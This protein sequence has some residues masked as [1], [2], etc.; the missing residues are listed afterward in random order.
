MRQYAFYFTRIDH[1]VLLS[2]LTYVQKDD[3]L[4]WA[5]PEVFKWLG[6]TVWG[7]PCHGQPLRFSFK[8]SFCQFVHLVGARTRTVA[9]GDCMAD[10]DSYS[11]STNTVRQKIKK[12][13]GTNQLRV[14]DV[15]HVWSTRFHF[16]FFL[17]CLATLLLRTFFPFSPSLPPSA[18]PPLSP[19]SLLVTPF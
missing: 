12:I 19:S 11:R 1:F 10:D 6:V 5:C 18:S 17:Y 14:V 8:A 7:P 13:K 2:V 9:G 16:L 15:Q 4:R 3:A